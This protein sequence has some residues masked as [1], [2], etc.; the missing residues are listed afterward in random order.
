MEAFLKRVLPE[1]GDYVVMTIDPAQPKGKDVRHVNGLRTVGSVV[2]VA[3]RLSQLPVHVYY[4]VGSFDGNRN[5]PKAKRCLFLD[6]DAK[7]FGSKAETG[8]QLMIFCRTLGFPVPSIIV[9][10]GGGLHAYWV[11]DKDIDPVAWKDIATKLKQKC[12]ELAFKADPSCTDDVARVLR[13]PGTLNHK[14]SPPIACRVVSD[15][16]KVYDPAALLQLLMPVQV[17]AAAL[18]AGS[19]GDDLAK[20]AGETYP[21]IP[22]FGVEIAQRCGIMKEALETGG[23]DHSEPLWSNLL[24]LL[25]FCEDGTVVAPLVSQGH[26]AYDEKTCAKKFEYKLQRRA[27]GQLKPVLCS[28]FATYKGS[29][30][31]TC[32]YNGS[33]RTPLVLGKRE[34]TSFLPA[35]YQ[36]RPTGI[37]KVKKGITPEEPDTIT[38]AF[39]YSISDVDLL[40]TGAGYMVKATYSSNH[41]MFRTEMP[42]VLLADQGAELSKT[43]MQSGII[44]GNN[45]I[46]ELKFIMTHWLKKLQD[47]KETTRSQT[48]NMGWG[49]RAGKTVFA[50]GPNIFHSDGKTDTFTHPEMQLLKD[51]EPMG[52]REAWDHAASVVM[53]DG[54]Q[55]IAA[56]VLT[57]FSAPLMKFTGAAGI[58]FSACSTNSGTGKTTALKLAQAVWAHPVRSMAMLDDTPNSVAKKL[59]FINNLPAYWDEVRLTSDFAAFI[60][61]IFQMGQGK[62]KARLTSAVKQQE[63]GTWET[64]IIMAS[65][66]RI[67]DHVDHI[68]R[69]SNA[70]RLR[71]FEVTVP[72]VADS[73]ARASV[74]RDIEKLN[75]NYGHVGQQYAKFMASNKDKVERLVH[76]IQ[77]K[78]VKDLDASPEERFWTAFVASELAAAK[79]VTQLGIL[80]VDYE[81]LKKWLYSEFLSQRIGVSKSYLAPE[82]A[83]VNAVMQFAEQ[84]RDQLVVTEFAG[85]QQGYGALL[86]QPVNKEIVA[87]LARHDKILRIKERPFKEWVHGTLHNSPTVLVAT[88]MSLGVATIRKASVTAGIANTTSA[89]FPCIEIDLSNSLFDGLIET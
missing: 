77:D 48:T 80:T 59:G 19:V 37:Y 64:M 83:A 63:M 75:T 6:L 1:G 85:G 11:F 58:T 81:R 2:N 21:D 56:I 4:A 78:V 54:R 86:V 34:A 27:D 29:I 49:I 42:I 31:S 62:E 84:Y 38:L 5:A 67:V 69:A 30:C 44:A 12:T 71:V 66:E 18:L 51:Y 87:L 8:K 13:I 41:N 60:K 88:L 50:A 65:N 57:A 68:V 61:M 9:D 7:D 25:A 39:P 33:I 43:L 35:I 23:K 36:M 24:S 14:S 17:G 89:R 79:L 53:A 72:K 70:G 45:H 74:G 22:Y 82:Q 28:T 16:G 26:T 3:Q 15:S 52:K 55:A 46:N 32:S 47:I 73:A 76:L 10:S 20:P 40:T